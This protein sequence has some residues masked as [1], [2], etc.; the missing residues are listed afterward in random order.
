[1]RRGADELPAGIELI[2]VRSVVEAVKRA[3]I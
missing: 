3:L 1:M 2:P